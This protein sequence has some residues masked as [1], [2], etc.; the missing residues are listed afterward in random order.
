MKTP[1]TIPQPQCPQQETVCA[2][3]RTCYEIEETHL[4]KKGALT[5]C[6]TPPPAPKAVNK[7]HWCLLLGNLL[8]RGGLDILSIEYEKTEHDEYAIIVFAKGYR[9][10]VCITAN[11]YAA[12]VRDVMNHV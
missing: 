8:A 1:N 4:R 5:F 6:K 9:K 3:Q 10:K 7:A 2:F 11:S 12:I